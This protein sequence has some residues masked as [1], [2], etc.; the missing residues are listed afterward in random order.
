MSFIAIQLPK[1]VGYWLQLFSATLD[2]YKAVVY[3]SLHA[4]LSSRF[5]CTDDNHP[6][7]GPHLSSR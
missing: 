4:F 5:C 1:D 2:E 7:A 6:S 3:S